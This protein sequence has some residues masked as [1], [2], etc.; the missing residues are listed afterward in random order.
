MDALNTKV[1]VINKHWQGVAETSAQEAICDIYRGA[2]TAIDTERM[3]AV[4]WAEWATLPIRAGDV[5]V[6]S[7]R[8]PVRVPTVICKSKYASMPKRAPK[9]SK[10]GVAKRDKRICQVSG[11]FAPDGNIDHVYARKHGGRDEWGNTVWMC[12]DLNAKKG[13]KSL[14]EMGWKL[15]RRPEKPK[16]EPMNRLIEPRHPDWRNFLALS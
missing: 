13:H 10:R 5:A 7:L 15:L 1:L 4:T 2:S 16:E 12:R 11:K 9:W 14:E 8:G 6:Q 3:L